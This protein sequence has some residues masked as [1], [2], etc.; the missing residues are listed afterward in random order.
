[1]HLQET[2]S[3]SIAWKP[4]FYTSYFVKSFNRKGN[5]REVGVG[6]STIDNP[7]RPLF[8]VCG[9][10]TGSWGKSRTFLRTWSRQL[11]SDDEMSAQLDNFFFSI[12]AFIVEGLSQ[13]LHFTKTW[14]SSLEDRQ[15]APSGQL[16]KRR[17]QTLSTATIRVQV[18]A[19]F[20][21]N[22]PLYI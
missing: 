7:V 19:T 10:I 6:N 2:I 22:F 8:W 20:D 17:K 16:R 11:S 5:L 3:W 21:C 1:M 15:A 12:V 13:R 4:Q 14:A 9:W 18:F